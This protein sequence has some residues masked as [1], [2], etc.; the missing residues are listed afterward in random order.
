MLTFFFS[1]YF[2]ESNNL[3]QELITYIEDKLIFMYCSMNSSFNKSKN[4]MNSEED[5]NEEATSERSFIVGMFKFNT[6]LKAAIKS[7]EIIVDD[8]SY[9]VFFKS[10]TKVKDT[11][12]VKQTF[13]S[14]KK[15]LF[16]YAS[17]K[18]MI[19][20]QFL[21]LKNK[22]LEDTLFDL[23]ELLNKTLSKKALDNEFD[24]VFTEICLQLVSMNNQTL[25]DYVLKS[26]R[27]IAKYLGKE[28][29]EILFEFINSPSDM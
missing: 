21:F 14:E 16:F 13:N 22:E 8:E 6:Q 29:V 9:K 28:S 15:K 7:K 17:L 20:S 24:K 4:S 1:Q 18:L 5:E 11:L 27:R 12:K 25:T 19:V 23:E 3:Y 26:F 2:S 10:L